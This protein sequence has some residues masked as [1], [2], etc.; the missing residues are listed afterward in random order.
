MHDDR[1]R[2]WTVGCVIICKKLFLLRRNHPK[3][4]QPR[5]RTKKKFVIKL[6]FII[7]AK[8]VFENAEQRKKTD[9]KRFLWDPNVET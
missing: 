6:M 9:I 7:V 2:M 8:S 5:G 3:H 4:F 1:I